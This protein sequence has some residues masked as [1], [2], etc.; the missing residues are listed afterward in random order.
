MPHYT[1][2]QGECLMG[3]ALRHGFQDW[4]RIYEHP[5]NEA[6]RRKRPFA[7]I[8]HPGDVLFIP[9][10]EGKSL[11]AS[12]GKAHTFTVKRP[13]RELCLTLRDAD[14]EPLVNEP[15]LLEVDADVLEGATGPDGSL[16]ELIP[17][18]ADAAKLSVGERVYALRLA[19]L[20]PTGDT[21]DQGISGVQARLRNLG[22]DPGPVDGV[23]SE[24]TRQALCAFEALQGLP[25]T[26]APEG[27]T[28]DT[29]LQVHGC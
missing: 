8:L 21:E 22:F 3:I 1:V 4:T 20:N 5:R 9:D 25:I 26:G 23:L 24:R 13:M 12:T 27:R 15:Y 7:H 11:G 17:L 16:R 18:R 2:K 6:L 29:L 19:T 14:G 28:L 10:P